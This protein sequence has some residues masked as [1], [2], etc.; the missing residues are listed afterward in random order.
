MSRG[1]LT[2]KLFGRSPAKNVKYGCLPVDNSQV[3]T[4]EGW[5]EYSDLVVGQDVLSYN[6]N[7]GHYEWKPITKLWYYENAE[8]VILKNKW[9]SLESTRDHNWFGYRSTKKCESLE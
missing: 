9:V 1:S 6:Q 2:I 3:L 8:V 7:L 4:R 5:V